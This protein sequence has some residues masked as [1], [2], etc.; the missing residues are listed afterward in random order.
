VFRILVVTLQIFS[1]LRGCSLNFAFFDLS[2]LARTTFSDNFLTAQNFAAR[3]GVQFFYP[4]ATT[5]LLDA[6]HL[7]LCWYRLLVPR[8]C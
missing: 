4:S 5:F 7:R 3:E 2:F 8:S 1:N 6:L